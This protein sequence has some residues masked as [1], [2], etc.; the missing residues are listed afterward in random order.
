[1]QTTKQISG[2]K[3]E[4][5]AVSYLRKQG[6]KIIDRNFRSRVGEIDIIAID[7]DT[8]VFIEVKA[9]SSNEFG[10]PLDAIT[11]WKMNSLIKTAQYYKLKNP[12][13]PEAMRID[14]VAIT[15]DHFNDLKTIELVKNISVC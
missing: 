10:S 6:Y 12:R 14:A 5:L 4:E 13:L 9:R 11:Y 3:G 1:M 8:L 2:A 15:L 7:K